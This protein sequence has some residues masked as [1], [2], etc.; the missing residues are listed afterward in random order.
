MASQFDILWDGPS[1]S[2]LRHREKV[3][4]SKLE[5]AYEHAPSK[6]ATRKIHRITGDLVRVRHAI[7]EAV[8][9][10]RDLIS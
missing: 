3:L 10:Q 6:R 2:M 8:A 5:R 4:I 7:A 1:L 9:S